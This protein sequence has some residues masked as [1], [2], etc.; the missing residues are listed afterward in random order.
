MRIREEE[1]ARRRAGHDR[2]GATTRRGLI[3]AMSDR[4]YY[5]ILGVDHSSSQEE[6]AQAF[7]RLARQHHPDMHPDDAEADA[8]FKQI[9]E[10]YQTLSDPERRAHYDMELAS[11]QTGWAPAAASSA[12]DEPVIVHQAS[13]VIR[14]DEVEGA[15]RDLSD[16]LGS[17]ASILADELRGA[18]RD[19][20]AQLDQLTRNSY[21]SQGA[22]PRRPGFPPPQRR[23]S[24]PP[25]GMPPHGGKPPSD[26]PRGRPPK[27]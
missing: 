25:R 24:P 2:N 17:S 3:C 10:A 6:L 20:A 9:N 27:R 4:D 12:S 23:P 18:L 8:R 16:A 26:P 1:E 5:A 7:R 22:W 19:F 13:V 15:L 21:T 11:S 14:S